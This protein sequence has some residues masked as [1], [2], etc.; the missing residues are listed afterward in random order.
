MKIGI[1][2]FWWSEDNYGQ[3]LQCYAL[4]KY[5]R[6]LGHD[7]YLIRY[8][9]R[10]DYIKSFTWK[11][12]IKAFNPLK[13]YRFSLGKIRKI[14]NMWE[15]NDNLRN[16][17]GFRNKFI[18]QSERIY[19]SYKELVEN[20]PLADVYIVGSDQVW[21][22]FGIP[23]NKG[24]NVFNA[25]LLNFGDSHVRRIAYA[26]SFGREE[27]CKDLIE[28]FTPMLKKLDY[29]SVREM[30]GLEICRQCGIN[31]AE[32]V[33]DPSML[34]GADI[35]RTLYRDEN[36]IEKP[37]KPYCFLYLLGNEFDFS[38]QAI[39]EWARKECIEV[40]YITGN[41]KRDKYI[42]TYVEIPAWIYL[43]E[44]AEY[45]ITN[46]YHCTVFSLLYKKKFGVI[47]LSGKSMGMNSRFDT[48]FRLFGLENRFIDA[49]FS[50]LNKE[51]NWLSVLNTFKDGI[52]ICK[53]N[54]IIYGNA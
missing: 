32:L 39:Y 54:R 25:Y 1:M 22:T 13:L 12:I 50:I 28:V 21:N 43:L 17:E 10:N 7:A 29:V 42:K 36:N 3:L 24:I 30:S 23:I 48:I 37:N 47:P 5:L 4:Q 11:R 2:T 46:S 27:I 14:V 51:I 49:D 52:N 41:L 40:I 8:D 20:P 38:V 15:R 33:P 9:P 44:H 53:L 34:L 6:N 31:S 45:I 16:F 35:Y 26:A 18:N 19:F